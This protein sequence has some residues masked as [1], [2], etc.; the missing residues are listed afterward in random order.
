MNLKERVTQIIRQEWGDHLASTEFK[1]PYEGEDLFVYV[2]TTTVL[3]SGQVSDRPE[4]LDRKVSKGSG[5]LSVRGAAGS[6]D[7]RRAQTSSST[8][9]CA[10]SLRTTINVRRGCVT[11]SGI[12]A[13]TSASWSTS[14]TTW[15]RRSRV[16]VF[17]CH[18]SRDKCQAACYE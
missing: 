1:G 3:S 12:S 11:A 15:Y 13:T 5:D 2:N 4:R 17:R 16:W 9:T 6:G 8:L 7:P 18:V 14:W 10:R